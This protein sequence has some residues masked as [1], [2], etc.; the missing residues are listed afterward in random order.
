M[1]FDVESIGLHGEGWAVGWVI[2]DD[3]GQVVDEGYA[4]CPQETAQGDDASREW[5]KANCPQIEPTHGGPNEVREAFWQA[6]Q[7]AKEQGATLWADCGWPVEANFLSACVA[8]NPQNRAWNGP[9]PLHEIATVFEVAGVDA[10]AKLERLED[11]PEHHPLG[12]AKQS[13]RLL[14]KYLKQ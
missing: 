9:Y 3:N 11:E 6:W 10:T 14:A 1:I 7:K 2:L 5:V 4:A 13:A 8:A 12:D